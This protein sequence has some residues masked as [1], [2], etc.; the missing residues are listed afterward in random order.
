[1]LHGGDLNEAKALYPEARGA[2]IDLSTGINPNVY[3]VR[4]LEVDAFTRLPS[5]YAVRRLEAVAARTYGAASPDRVAA[6][7]GSQA[8]IQILPRLRATCRVA[9]IG[10]TY[11]EHRRAWERNGHAVDMVESLQEACDGGADVVV[12]VNPN[13]PDGRIMRPD[14]L[15]AAAARLDRH[16][17]WLVVDEAFAD[18]E[19][20]VSLVPYD[21][22]GSI[23]LRSFGKSYGLAGIRLGFSVSSPVMGDRL[24][25]ELGPWS[26]SGPAVAIGTAALADEA[27]LA[28]Q[29]TDLQRAAAQIDDLLIRTGFEVVGGTRLFRLARHAEAAGWFE[30]LARNRIWVRK[31]ADRPD[32]LRFG[33]IVSSKLPCLASALGI[34]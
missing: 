20:G 11:S 10:P 13:N 15:A 14:I 31:F 6:A 24:K 4:H 19:D 17:G 26:V 12:V 27:W 32:L 8:L 25:D 18:L 23:V 29:K 2:W 30:R 28:E 9:I 34:R 1:V 7:P 21:A 5:A 3:P 16:G 33:N 22:P